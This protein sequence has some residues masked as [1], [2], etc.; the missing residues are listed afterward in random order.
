MLHGEFSS[1][2]PACGHLPCHSW[3][4]K[5]AFKLYHSIE[6]ERLMPP[7]VSLRGG[8][9]IRKLKYKVGGG[10]CWQLN[11]SVC[12]FLA[13]WNGVLPVVCPKLMG[14]IFVYASGTLE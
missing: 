5:L 1:V 4:S 10:L 9:K 12:T 3:H 11:G 13:F 14:G 6:I 2:D 8:K 7:I